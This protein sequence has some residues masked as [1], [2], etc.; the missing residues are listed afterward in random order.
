MGGGAQLGNI[1]MD[2]ATGRQTEYTVFAGFLAFLLGFGVLSAP[3]T[4]AQSR[5]QNIWYKVCT[6]SPYPPTNADVQEGGICQTMVDI[7]DNKTG[8]LVGR[9]AIGNMGGGRYRLHVMVPLGYAL[10]PGALA[11]IGD[12]Q[13][14]KLAFKR[15]DWAGCYAEAEAGS[16]LPRRMK[17]GSKIAYLFADTKGKAISV[18]VPLTGFAA[19]FDGPA[20]TVGKYRESVKKINDFIKSR[21]TYDRHAGQEILKVKFSALSR[22]PTTHSDW[23]KLCVDVAKPKTPNNKPNHKPHDKPNDNDTEDHPDLLMKIS[24]RTIRVCLTQIDVRDNE[25]SILTGKLALRE[26]PGQDRPQLMALLPLGVSLPDGASVT[27]GNSKPYKLSFTTCDR[28]G[29]YAEV[30]ADPSI[31]DDLRDNTQAAYTGQDESGATLTVRVKLSGFADAFEGRPTPMEVYK[32]Q[33]RKL[34]EEIR[35]KRRKQRDERGD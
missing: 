34:A 11:R 17:S 3:A 26:V 35:A 20:I 2:K 4:A 33:Q 27:I 30:S 25:T 12:G 19:V 15:C 29:C 10:A 7:R 18:P 5:P 1:T 8:V 24:L 31:A 6:N 32:A 23:Y 14:I 16:E 9:I 21:P 22:R 13:P 28:A